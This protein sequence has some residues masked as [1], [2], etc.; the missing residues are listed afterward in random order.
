MKRI[1]RTAELA[2]TLDI[3]SSSFAYTEHVKLEPDKKRGWPLIGYFP[4]FYRYSALAEDP[5]T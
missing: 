5:S 4:V 3:T 1:Y 2:A